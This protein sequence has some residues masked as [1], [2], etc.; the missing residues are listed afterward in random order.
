MKSSLLLACTLLACTCAANGLKPELSFDLEERILLDSNVLRLSDADRD[1]LDDDPLFQTDVDGVA[2]VK[3]EHRLGMDLTWRLSSRKGLVDRLQKLVGGRSGRGRLRLGYDGKWSQYESSSANGYNSHALR[4]Q[5]LPRAGW[6]FQLNWRLLDNFYLRQFTDRDTGL[7]RGATFDGELI[8]ATLRFRLP[9]WGGMER[10]GVSL[11]ASSDLN[12]Y[13]GWFTEYDTEAVAFGLGLS[14]DLPLEL[15]ASLGY[16]FV[17]T[18]NVGFSGAVSSYL[19][20]AGSDDEGGDGSHQEDQYRLGLSREF[21][22]P[23]GLPALDLDGGFLVR[24]RFY[25]SS[26][27]EIDDPFHYGRHDRRYNWDL[28]ASVSP[29]KD[30]RLQLIVEREWRRTTAPYGE[31]GR[32]KD[33]NLTRIGLGLRWSMDIS[34]DD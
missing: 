15:R 4:L 18:D 27:G 10:I 6:G 21:R 24:D 32:V 14:A 28:R 2:G 31:I 12:Y 13:N 11:D 26:L 17:D 23:A 22:L 25:T 30:L 20:A 16:S 1:R 19:P 3:A 33:Y 34:L 8:E 29:L 7:L 9:D 5:W